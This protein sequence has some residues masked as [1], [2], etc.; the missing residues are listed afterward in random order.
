[1]TGGNNIAQE[2]MRSKLIED[3]RVL[4]QE[5]LAPRSSQYDEG[6][7]HPTEN[8]EDLFNHGLL[9]ISVPENHGGMD[10]DPL[11]YVM[12]LEEIAKGCSSTSM[13]LH[14]HSTVLR[15]IAATATPQQKD[16]F[17]PEVVDGGKMFGSWGSE[18]NVSLGRNLYFET[19]V[20]ASDGGFIINGVKH[21][22]TMAG[23]ASYMQ[24][25]CSLGGSDDMANNAMLILVPADSPGLSITSGWNTLG[26]RATVSPSVEFKDCFV[27]ESHAL[28]KPG[29]FL[30]VGV[31]ESFPLGYAAVYLGTATSALEFA[32]EYCKTRVFKPDPLPISNDPIIQRHLGDI[33]VHLDA[34]RA[35]LYQ[36]ASQWDQSEPAI[37]GLLAAKAKY[38]CG[39]AALEV[40]SRAIQ[41][42]G[43]RSA[44]KN[45]PLERAFRD[46]RTATLMPPNADV[47]LANIGKANLGQLGAMFKVD[48]P[49]GS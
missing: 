29:E 38:L 16:R 5:R 3:V 36:C 6:A 32:T 46:V 44:L 45:L 42:V 19:S 22:C 33:S 13:T 43:G 15:F 14:M 21:F 4:T 17:Y 34:A 35:V 39:E 30:K 9:A 24:V 28:G 18:P 48:G 7:T 8:W 12:V 41:I 1:M 23:A 20:E 49:K 10:L 31:V 27:E 2:K 47:M 26:M 25:F 40:T 11:S 37:K